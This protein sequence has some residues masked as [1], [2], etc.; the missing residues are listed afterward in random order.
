MRD[1]YPVLA[2]LAE[3]R[4]VVMF[5]LPGFGRSAQA[6]VKYAPARYAAVLSRVIAAYGP[7]PVDVVGHSMGGAI[8]LFHAAAYPGA[9]APPDRRRRRGH[10]APRR[11]G[12]R[13]TCAA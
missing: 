9:G 5:D 12:R 10:P 6:N 4:R 7:G 1:W 11:L 13:T 8:S 3:H 2:P